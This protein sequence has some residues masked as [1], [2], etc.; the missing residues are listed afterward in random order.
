VYKHAA[1]S[2]EELGMYDFAIGVV[3]EAIDF[4]E[5]FEGV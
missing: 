2:G 1:V 4:M 3:K 5:K